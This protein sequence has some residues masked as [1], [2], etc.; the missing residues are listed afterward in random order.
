MTQHR[1]EEQ[2]LPSQAV[3]E[4]AQGM[5]SALESSV[6]MNSEE[7]A[8]LASQVQSTM[9]TSQQMQVA[10]TPQ[11]A[12]QMNPNATKGKIAPLQA[13]LQNNQVV[14]AMSAVPVMWQQGAPI[15]GAPMQGASIHRGS[16]PRA[17]MPGA[18]YQIPQLEN[19]AMIPQSQQ[20]A[21]P[22]EQQHSNALAISTLPNIMSTSSIVKPDDDVDSQERKKA[23][24]PKGKS[25]KKGSTSDKPPEEKSKTNRDRN[26]E[27]ARSTR[28]RKKAYVLKLKEM[29]QGLQ[30]IQTEEIRQRRVA[31]QK[32]MVQK[33]RRH[34]IQTVLRY[35]SNYESDVNKWAALLDE[36]FWFKQPVTPFRS[37]RRSDV[38]KVRAIN[39]NQC[40]RT[41]FRANH[42]N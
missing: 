17:P 2:Q 6:A 5:A 28:L 15:P 12:L 10:N 3:A 42:P 9:G 34:N 31:V 27:H 39:R 14:A 32:M 26:R 22:M 16:M 21:P 40:E 18:P 25:K 19:H 29:A 7:M 23:E 4:H 36:S 1:H 30:G 33:I 11:P 35:H 24:K 8:Q 37:F 13:Q 41:R 38:V 20:T